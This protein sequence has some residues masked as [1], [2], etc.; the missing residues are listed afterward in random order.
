MI[1]LGVEIKKTHLKI[2]ALTGLFTPLASAVF[3]KNHTGK[4]KRWLKAVAP[5]CEE[6]TVCFFDE[7]EF[8]KQR[9]P[10]YL[11]ETF[12]DTAECYTVNHRVLGEIINTF[13]DYALLITGKTQHHGKAFFLASARRIIAQE[14]IHYYDI[15]LEKMF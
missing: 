13:H 3:Q 5:I 6:K 10:L 8:F 9:P 15:E 14:H 12:E 11:L 2:V 1:Y 7:L 4:I